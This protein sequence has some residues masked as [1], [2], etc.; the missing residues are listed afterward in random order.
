MFYTIYKMYL[1]LYIILRT[2]NL[3]LYSSIIVINWVNYIIY[4]INLP[5]IYVIKNHVSF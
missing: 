3:R 1:S 5:N 2:H 4:L